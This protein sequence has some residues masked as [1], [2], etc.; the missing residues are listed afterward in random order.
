[1]IT[2]NTFYTFI[3]NV[4]E[5]PF[6]CH[7]VVFNKMLSVNFAFYIILWAGLDGN[8]RIDSGTKKIRQSF[9]NKEE[10]F[11]LVWQKKLYATLLKD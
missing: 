7:F 10:F 4:V 1:M 5:R 11:C 9:G 3:V 6:S 8:K 2:C